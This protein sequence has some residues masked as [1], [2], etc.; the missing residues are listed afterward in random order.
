DAAVPARSVVTL[1]LPG[2]PDQ[3]AE[4]SYQDLDPPHARANNRLVI[5]AA[6]G[7][8]ARHERFDDK[9]T[10]QRLM[11]SI[12][13][14]HSGEY[15]G[16][17][18]MLL[19]ML[20]SLLMPLFT[21]SG[22]MLY[23]DRRRKQAALRAVAA[24]AGTL[25]PVA[26]R[27]NDAAP[28]L[29][30]HA[31][32]TGTAERLAWQT[33]A[34]LRAGGV[35]ARV[36]PLASLGP[37]ALASASRLLVVAST[38]GEGEPPDALRPYARRVLTRDLDL[39]GLQYAVL[40]LGDRS[41]GDFCAFGHAVDRWLHRQG[42]GPLFDLVE[43]DDGD[44]GALRR[45]QHH[46]AVLAGSTA[47]PDWRAPA[48]RDATLLARTHLNPGSPGGPVFLVSL[49]PDA[50]ETWQAGD[51]AE[52]GPRQAEAEVAR[53]LA[54]S[55]H[56]ASDPVRWQ[57]AN[58]TLGAA[59]A[60]AT[61]PAVAPLAGHSAQAVA[62]AMVPLPHREYSIASLPGDGRL[63]LLVRQVTRADG[64]PGLGSGWLTVGAPVG[65]PVAL[66]V[67]A[68]PN[69]RPPADDRPLVLVGNG[70]GL[71]GLHALLRARIV[72]GHRRNW[73]LFGE[74]TA[75]H[76]F[77][78]RDRLAAAQAGGFLPHLDLAFSRDGH[79]RPYVQDRLREQA[80]RLRAWVADGAAIHV[81]G[82]LE[83]MA[84]GVEAALV[85]VLGA[86][87]LDA[88]TAEGRYRRDVY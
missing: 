22:W 1:R 88:L 11:A 52:I 54:A 78:F 13:P 33:A 49:Q 12:F 48:Y 87:A 28:V 77:H 51:I 64:R 81:C 73:L 4:F 27:T 5:D 6:T 65:G 61:L 25:G 85:D 86:P 44:A 3:P 43:V 16:L 15:F 14:L 82:S 47:L 66:R 17:A 83:G 59:L 2:G 37:D 62:D 39:A 32:Q 46:L 19:F 80:D 7:A 53:W 9:P 36:L 18:G 57:G 76:D 72:A 68:N 42:A 30:A 10:G 60:A 8:V 34:S 35:D 63:E 75:A 45:W 67:R 70:T 41:Y 50:A 40:A 20:A 56:A 69:F 21:I 23:L 58:M 55:G 71:A 24:T 79:G 84:P 26:A 31:S 29:V 74:R 38:F